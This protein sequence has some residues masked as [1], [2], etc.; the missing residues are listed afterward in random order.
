MRKATIHRQTKETDIRARLNLDG[1]GAAHIST[2]IHFLDHM[3][4]QIARHGAIDLD[5][6]AQGDLHI[7]QHHTVEDVELCW[8]KRSRRPWDRSAAFCA[9]GIT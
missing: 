2:G 3:L 1:R 9:P 7:D 8:V 6:N 4:E 5:L